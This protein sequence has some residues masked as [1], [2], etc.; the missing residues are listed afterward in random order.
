MKNAN[1]F[2]FQ[3][4][5]TVHYQSYMNKMEIVLAVDESLIPDPHRLL[6]DLA[7]SL[8]LIKDAAIAVKS[9]G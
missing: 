9:I 5:L 4:A 2:W 6:D 3:Q 1:N 7:E 8:Q